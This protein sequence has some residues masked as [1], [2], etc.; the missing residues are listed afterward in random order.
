MRL[1]AQKPFEARQDIVQRRMTTLETDPNFR[2]AFTR[3]TWA[4]VVLGQS[5]WK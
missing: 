2:A 5:Q 1:A 4:A 3:S